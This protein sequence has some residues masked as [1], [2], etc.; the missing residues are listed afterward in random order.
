MPHSTH[1]IA[2]PYP[3][4]FLIAYKRTHWKTNREEWVLAHDDVFLY[5]EDAESQLAEWIE[6]GDPEDPTDYVVLQAV[7]IE[8][9]T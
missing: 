7:P 6:E 9:A 8:D 2:P 3:Q 1:T 5:R 4:A